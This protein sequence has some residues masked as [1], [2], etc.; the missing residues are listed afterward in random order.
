MHTLYQR[1]RLTLHRHFFYV[2]GQ[3]HRINVVLS[4]L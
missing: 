1:L 4:V 3:P 2:F